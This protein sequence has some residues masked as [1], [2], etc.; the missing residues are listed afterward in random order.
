[1]LL[2]PFRRLEASKDAR[3]YGRQALVRLPLGIR[4]PRGY[5]TLLSTDRDQRGKAGTGRLQE[6]RGNQQLPVASVRSQFLKRRSSQCQ[7]SLVLLQ[8]DFCLNLPFI[9]SA[10]P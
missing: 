3:A 6:P 4:Y 2:S 1:M 8:P 9:R 5:Y 10:R 7:T